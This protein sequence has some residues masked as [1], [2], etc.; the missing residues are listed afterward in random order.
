MFLSTF[1]FY[2][3]SAEKHCPCKVALY[4]TGTIMVASLCNSCDL[5]YEILPLRV[6]VADHQNRTVGPDHGSPSCVVMGNVAAC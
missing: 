4:L 1:A 6:T 5:G 3:L 2:I